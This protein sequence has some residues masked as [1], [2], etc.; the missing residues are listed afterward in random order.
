MSN[1]KLQIK[2]GLRIS[3]PAHQVFEAIV[4]P[5]HMKGYFIA[6]GSG[7]LEEGKIVEWT[8]PEM[9]AAFS[10]QVKKAESPRIIVFAWRAP[11]GS[12]TTVKMQLNAVSENTTFL[13][14]TE[15]EKEA[16]SSGIQWLKSN[17]EGWANFLACLKAY[18]E[19]GI[20]LRQGA[21]D[22]SQMPTQET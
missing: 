21:F 5:A 2:V 22:P 20:N 17:T 7:R 15:G 3:K 18:L 1:Q 16:D 6:K 9:D 8:F 10:V 12:E 19:Y 13:V 4:D 14:I 11:D